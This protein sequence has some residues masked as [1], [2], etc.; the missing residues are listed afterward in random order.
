MNVRLLMNLAQNLDIFVGLFW[1]SE[2]KLMIGTFPYIMWFSS[3]ELSD[4]IKISDLVTCWEHLP[5]CDTLY[6]LFIL[7]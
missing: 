2:G 5:V 1:V 6:T 7:L 3:D 4:M